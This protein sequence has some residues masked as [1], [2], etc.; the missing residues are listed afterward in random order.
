MRHATVILACIVVTSLAGPAEARP[1]SCGSI[2][3]S[4]EEPLALGDLGFTTPGE[5]RRTPARRV[6][7][8]ATPI[9]SP[10]EEHAVEAL[11]GPGLEELRRQREQR[12]VAALSSTT[13]PV[14]F[15]VIHDGSAGFLDGSEVNS[16]IQHLNSTY[17][18]TG[19]S[20]E[21]TTTTYTDNG[22][23]FRM[24]FC[25]PTPCPYEVAAKNALNV[26]PYRT[27][28]LYSIQGS[29]GILGWATYP[30]ELTSD[31]DFD[32]VVIAFETIPNGGRTNYEEGDTATHEVG[33]WLGLYH[34]FHPNTPNG[35]FVCDVNGDYVSDTAVERE[36]T[37]FCP[38]SADTCPSDPGD[39]N[40]HNFMQ[41]VYDCC[42]YRFTQGQID[43]M[44]V[45]TA[46]YRS[47][48]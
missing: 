27:L 33:H 30:W 47:L 48:L 28:N 38:S 13:I 31:P 24:A 2:V 40:I 44:Q 17:Q 29:G 46:I 6:E 42:M 4:A 45:M 21:L 36:P 20:F 22:D 34:T 14:A 8:C 37:F 16:Q 7:R 15:H 26:D 43:R 25:R 41:Y 1:P 32:G 19:F 12:G 18:G 9:P 5:Q 35:P 23:W 39:D 11:I 10:A 3:L